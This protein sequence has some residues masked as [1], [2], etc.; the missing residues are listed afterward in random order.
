LN[1]LRTEPWIPNQDERRVIKMSWSIVSKAAERSSR[2]RHDI[3]SCY[4]V[5]VTVETVVPSSCHRLH[6]TVVNFPLRLHIR[7]SSFLCSPSLRCA[8]GV[9]DLGVTSDARLSFKHTTST[10]SFAAAADAVNLSLSAPAYVVQTVLLVFATS[11]LDY[12]NAM[13]CGIAALVFCQLPAIMPL[14]WADYCRHPP[15]S[16]L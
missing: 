14:C 4:H 13:S 5:S 10:A 3:P 16:S 15:K 9:E 11:C 12:C 6:I 1:Q 2:Q 8:D 7:E